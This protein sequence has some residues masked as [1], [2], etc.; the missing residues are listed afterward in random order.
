M[1]V[2]VCG[3][4]V[5]YKETNRTETRS[6]DG[7]KE[8]RKTEDVTRQATRQAERNNLKIVKACCVEMTYIGKEVRRHVVCADVLRREGRR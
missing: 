3:V 4:C 5:C 8:G 7:V 2:C 6:K 1:C